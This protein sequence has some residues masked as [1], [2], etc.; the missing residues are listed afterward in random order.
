[1]RAVA[2]HPQIGCDRSSTRAPRRVG[3]EISQ[4]VWQRSLEL[5]STGGHLDLPDRA[6]ALARA[7]GHDPDTMAHAL[8]LGRSRGR[9]PS[10]DET[11]RDG[12]RLLEQVVAYLGI[13]SERDEIVS[14]VTRRAATR[15]SRLLPDGRRGTRPRPRSDVTR[16]TS[17]HEEV[18]M[19]DPTEPWMIGDDLARQRRK[20]EA[21]LLDGQIPDFP[22]LTV[23][24][25]VADVLAVTDEGHAA[26]DVPD[27]LLERGH[28]STTITTVVDYLRR[29][30]PPST[31][32]I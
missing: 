3:L 1:M 9:H 11:T 26:L 25:L 31:G 29:Q 28:T 10:N 2:E 5:A 4:R 22:G 8:G 30:P 27:Y 20:R 12:L 6:L 19:P 18:D 15:P 14:P 21:R 24:D 32:A 13:R 7:A 17:R 23:A 16:A